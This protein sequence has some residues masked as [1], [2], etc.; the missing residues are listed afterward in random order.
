MFE[1][2]RTANKKDR[3]LLLPSKMCHEH[4]FLSK[5]AAQGQANNASGPKLAALYMQLTNKKSE[6][7]DNDSYAKLPPPRKYC[8]RAKCEEVGKVPVPKMTNCIAAIAVQKAA[9]SRMLLQYE[10]AKW[11]TSVEWDDDTA[12]KL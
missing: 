12:L 8:R 6:S 5:A 11:S 9:I 3:F 10:S 1:K 2:K 4:P 7:K